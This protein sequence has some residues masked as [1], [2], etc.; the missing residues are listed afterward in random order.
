MLAL[1]Q[2]RIRDTTNLSV[3]ADS[4]TDRKKAKNGGGT[5]PT[6]DYPTHRRTPY[7]QRNYL[8][9]ADYS[10]HSGAPF[11]TRVKP[12]FKALFST[13]HQSVVLV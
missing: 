4:S 6:A 8:L 10:T 2:K 11:S 1:T 12:G 13:E 3:C 9:T 7:S 5:C